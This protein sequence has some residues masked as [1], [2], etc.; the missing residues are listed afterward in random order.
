MTQEELKAILDLH[1][2]WKN[3][4]KGGK[5]AYLSGAD[6]SGAD[7]SDETKIDDSAMRFFPLACPE[8]GSFIGWKKTAEDLIVKLLIPEDAKRSSAFGRK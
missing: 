5:W 4:E 7:L 2:K 8:S 1:K 3:H 6:L